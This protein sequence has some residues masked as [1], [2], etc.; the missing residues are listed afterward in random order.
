MIAVPPVVTARFLVRRR[1]RKRTRR[2]RERRRS[3]CRPGDHFG[4]T[5]APAS[6]VFSFGRLAGGAIEHVE[7]AREHHQ[8][9]GAVLVEVE[10]G[11]AAD[12]D[13]LPFAA[14]L[15]LGRQ[16]LVAPP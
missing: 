14:G 6:P 8:D 7:L 13:A 11:E 10:V 2:I 3:V 15:L 9:V 16:V 1:G 4:S 12:R 5:I